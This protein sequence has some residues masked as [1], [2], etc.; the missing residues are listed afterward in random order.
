MTVSLSTFLHA[1][2]PGRE[3]VVWSQALAFPFSHKLALSGFVT[4]LIWMFFIRECY[5]GRNILLYPDAVAGLNAQTR[6]GLLKLTGF[7]PGFP[8]P[9]FGLS[10]ST[11]R[12]GFYSNHNCPGH[13]SSCIRETR[14]NQSSNLSAIAGLY[15]YRETGKPMF[16]SRGFYF[17]HVNTVSRLSQLVGKIDKF[18]RV[19]PAFSAS[20]EIRVGSCALQGLALP[21]FCSGKRRCNFTVTMVN[22]FPV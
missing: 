15:H 5:P 3:P 2:Y 18:R 14:V 11:V 19:M 13:G 1:F 17:L 12:H 6:A 10:L 20:W 21:W 4:G 9:A 16:Q 7:R 22:I 8:G